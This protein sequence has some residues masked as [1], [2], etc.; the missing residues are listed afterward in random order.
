MRLLDRIIG[1]A[2]ASLP[3][4]RGPVLSGVGGDG[5]FVR[6]EGSDRRYGWKEVEQVVAANSVELIGDTVL[7]ALALSDGS[8]LIVPE[9][10]A[11]WLALVNALTSSLPL[12]GTVTPDEWRLRLLAAPDEP[13]ELYQR[14]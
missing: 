5:L 4:R 6:D 11:H 14:Q 8:T 13:L 3:S 10:D 9:T 2:V 1:R 12:P 7:L